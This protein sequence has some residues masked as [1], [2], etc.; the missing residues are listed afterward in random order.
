MASAGRALR[1]LFS[2]ELW[3]DRDF[4]KLWA[5]QTLSLAG[6]Q[7]GSIAVPL[8][9]ILS[10]QASTF[11]VGVL[12]GLGSLP[13]LLIA[14]PAGVWVDRIKRRRLL[15]AADAWRGLVTLSVPLAAVI[16]ALTLPHLYAVAFLL[17]IGTVIFEFAYH[18]YL[19]HLVGQR[20]LVEG[21]SKL[22]VSNSAVGV[23]GP[24]VAGA[25]V[26]LLSAPIAILADG[27]SYL[28]SAGSLLLISKGEPA[29]GASAGRHLLSE[30][31]EGFDFVRGHPFLMAQVATTTTNNAFVSITLTLELLYLVRTLHFQPALIGL[32]FML[33]APGALLGSLLARPAI[34]RFGIGPSMIAAGSISGLC[35]LLIPAAGVPGPAAVVFVVG[36]VFLF[37]G[38]V[39]I[40]NIT[41]VSVRQA[42][43][44]GRLLGRMNG[45]TRFIT[46]GVIPLA[47]L[48]GGFLGESVGVRPALVVA[49]LGASLAPVWL[50]L[51]PVR[52]WRTL[53]DA[54][55]EQPTEPHRGA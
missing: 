10:L 42:I 46:W 18:S 49:G 3:L 11:E 52:R 14:L 9:A 26:Q 31:R 43:T 4:L 44:P 40:Y 1:R 24:G 13:Y 33:G 16:G 28:A 45:T 34:E 50:L 55:P 39:Q 7:V 38:G 22:Q 25:I 23:A 29:P 51:S 54:A 17:G 12:R 19:P 30:L 36:F 47:S 6:S 53:A 27:L 37:G 41:A 48:A 8:V 20:L 5:G 15:V 2:G 32:V 21:N 35:C